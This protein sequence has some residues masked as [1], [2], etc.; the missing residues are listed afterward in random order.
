M[1]CEQFLLKFP[2]VAHL[3]L[4][5]RYN[6]E[7]LA[8]SCVKYLEKIKYEEIQEN[9]HYEKISGLDKP[10]TKL[11]HKKNENLLQCLVQ[12]VNEVVMFVNG[13]SVEKDNMFTAR[14]CSEDHNL[15][16]SFT[17]FTRPS[18]RTFSYDEC[19]KCL[20][21]VVHRILRKKE[22]YM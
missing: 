3:V 7:M 13:E 1:D 12:I 21:D 2:S 17:I 20:F 8:D 5:E 10:I 9:E 19:K 15:K 18:G 16:C 6:L 4:A 11:L 22:N 14:T